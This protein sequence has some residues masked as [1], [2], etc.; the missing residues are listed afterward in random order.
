MNPASCLLLWD[1]DGT[2]VDT[3]PAF[4]KAF[5]VLKEAYPCSYFTAENFERLLK[6]WGDFWENCPLLQKEEAMHFYGNTYKMHSIEDLQLM[7]NAKSILTWAQKKGF[8]Q[9]LV[10]NK[11]QWAIDKECAHLG[12]KDYFERCVGV[13]SGLH[14]DRKPSVSYGAKALQGLS[15]EQLIVVGDSK[16]DLAFAENLGAIGI[17]IDRVPLSE[18]LTKPFVRVSSLK[19]VKNFLN[20]KIKE[21]F[22]CF[23]VKKHLFFQQERY[24]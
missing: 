18:S 23:E 2:L 6:N 19:E 10:S 11:V 21:D 3:R 14:P 4:V 1:W 17:Y 15:Y 22:P 24:K 8:R 20:E 13:E 12:V 7:P 9:I 16:D 5:E